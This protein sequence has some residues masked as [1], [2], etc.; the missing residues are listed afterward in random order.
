MAIDSERPEI[1]PDL[2]LVLVGSRRMSGRERSRLLQSGVSGRLDAVD[3]ED[4]R[5]FSTAA[6]LPA[7]PRLARSRTRD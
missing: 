4:A 3:S 1:F 5:L 6:V 2:R 7:L